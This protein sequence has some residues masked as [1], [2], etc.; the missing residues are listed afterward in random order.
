MKKNVLIEL[1]EQLPDEAEIW[2]YDPESDT[3]YEADEIRPK[4]VWR[5]K[6]Y[7]GEKWCQDS[8]SIFID[9]SKKTVYV[10]R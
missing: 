3:A 9:G 4:V 7:W 10:I 6:G 2:I 8:N 1:L 5:G